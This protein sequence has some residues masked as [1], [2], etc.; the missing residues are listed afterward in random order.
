M[1][2]DELVLDAIWEDRRFEKYKLYRFQQA[3][4]AIEGL[5]YSSSAM[6]LQIQDHLWAPME[7][8]WSEEGI[9]S[10]EVRSWKRADRAMVVVRATLLSYLDTCATAVHGQPASRGYI[11]WP[12]LYYCETV[13]REIA[14]EEDD[15]TMS[16][17]EA[18]YLCD[19]VKDHIAESQR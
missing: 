5:V 19:F 12:H 11:L 9:L 3:I 8:F 17:T 18:D 14:F 10:E 15:S 6:A 4:P 13:I 16:T 7:D 2:F 1:V